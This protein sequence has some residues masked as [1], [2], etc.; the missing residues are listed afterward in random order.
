MRAGNEAV[1]ATLEAVIL[2][3]APG[4]ALARQKPTRSASRSEMLDA[5]SDLCRLQCGV[6]R[7]TLVHAG[8][9][10]RRTYTRS[11]R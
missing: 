9:T 3:A 10:S 5:C 7:D 6:V 2:Q 8:L 1:N 4:S 11:T